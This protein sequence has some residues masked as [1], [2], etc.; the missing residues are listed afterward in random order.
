MRPEL[1]AKSSVRDGVMHCAQNVVEDELE[2]ALG[3]ESAV[4]KQR[5]PLRVIVTTAESAGLRGEHEE[6]LVVPHIVLHLAARLVGLSLA[7]PRLNVNVTENVA[8]LTGQRLIEPEI[9]L[10]DL[11][12]AEIVGFQRLVV[13]ADQIL[14]CDLRGVR[15]L[16]LEVVARDFVEVRSRPANLGDHFRNADRVPGMA[17]G[18]ALRRHVAREVVNGRAVSAD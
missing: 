7:C 14:L 2:S 13:F 10:C 8:E 15:W 1:D 5:V 11:L 18:E 3:L 9:R 16:L 6:M 12:V 4:A 17:L